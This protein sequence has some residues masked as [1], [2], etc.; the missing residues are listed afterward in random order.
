M[1]TNDSGRSLSP[2]TAFELLADPSRRGVLYVL[3]DSD[4]PIR[5]ERLVE[6]VLGREITPYDDRRR[7]HLEL[8][9]TAIPKLANSRFVEYDERTRRLRLTDPHDELR[10]YL[11]FARSMD[12]SE[13]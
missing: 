7:L 5:Y 1:S 8:H 3:L 11:R 6:R 2:S 13:S 10:P 4:G 12:E 9:H